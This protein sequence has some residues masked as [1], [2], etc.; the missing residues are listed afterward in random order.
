MTAAVP[1]LHVLRGPL[2]TGNRRADADGALYREAFRDLAVVYDD[3]DQERK[4]LVAE[5]I[6]HIMCEELVTYVG[7]ERGPLD[8]F[9]GRLQEPVQ[10][11]KEM[12]G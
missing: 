11:Y 1:P 12:L 6:M 2:N 8:R 5:A 7:A 3:L 10:S 9:M 4:A